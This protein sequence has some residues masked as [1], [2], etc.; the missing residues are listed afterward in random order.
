MIIFQKSSRRRN[1]RQSD[2]LERAIEVLGS[3]R[4]YPHSDDAAAV[5]A[6]KLLK[7]RVDADV[8]RSKEFY[9]EQRRNG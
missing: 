7:K 9:K 4:I 8:A 2:A 5:K 1:V 6:L 3:G